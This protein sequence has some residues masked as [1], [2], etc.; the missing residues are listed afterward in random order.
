MFPILESYIL[1]FIMV[2][3]LLAVSGESI[4]LV[5]ILFYSLDFLM[6]WLYVSKI[7]K[8]AKMKISIAYFCARNV[9]S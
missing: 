2:E 3:F 6:I 7:L 5:I 4:V 9:K 8:S 1:Y